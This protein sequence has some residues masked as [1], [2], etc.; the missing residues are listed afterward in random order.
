[1][2]ELIDGEDRIDARVEFHLNGGF[3]R[4]SFWM[5][6]PQT[7]ELPTESIPVELRRLGSWL[8][9]AFSPEKGW[10]I[11]G[12]GKPDSYMLARLRGEK[13]PTEET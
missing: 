12:P 10:K 3:T 5:G 8:S 7:I 4:L 6:G 11:R 9:F 13:R 1:M 2:A